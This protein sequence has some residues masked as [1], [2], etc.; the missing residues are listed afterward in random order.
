[1]AQQHEIRL[2]L[3]MNGGVS[4]AVWMGGVAHELDLIRRATTENTPASMGKDVAVANRWRALMQGPGVSDQRRLVIDVIAGTSAGGLNG[5]LLANVIAHNTTLDPAPEPEGEDQEDNDVV[6][7]PWLRSQWCD[8]GTLRSGKLIPDPDAE[9]PP[10]PTGSILDGEFFFKQAERLLTELKGGSKPSSMH[11][12]TLFTTASGL[13]PQEFEARD[14][15]QQPFLV[16]DHRF[17]YRFSNDHLRRYD[18]DALEFH[19]P[20]EEGG[21]FGDIGRLAV[22]ARASASFPVAFAPWNE[23]DLNN[24]ELRQ[25]PRR[26]GTSASWLMDGGVLDNA[27][28][29]PVLATVAAAPVSGHVSRYVMY[30]VPS[31][32]IGKGATT[33]NTAGN[34]PPSW[35]QTAMSVVNFP[36]EVDF[37]SDVE[38]L[39]S[40]RIEADTAWSDTQQAFDAARGSS[41]ERARLLSAAESLQPIYTRGRAAG[42]V[43]EALTVA[44]AG[45]ITALDDSAAAPAKDVDQILQTVPQWTPLE[46]APVNP[47]VESP[48]EVPRWPWGMG[49]AERVVRTVLRAV[50]AQTATAYHADTLA[51]TALDTL[52]SQLTSLTD[53]RRNLHAIRSAAEHEIARLGQPRNELGKAQQPAR[54]SPASEPAAVAEAINEAFENLRVQE[55]LGQEIK[56]VID[57]IPGGAELVRLALAVE[58]VERCM[59][60]R[61]P[62]QRSA[63]FKFIRLGPDIP[64][65]FLSEDDQVRATRLGDRVIYGT[66]VGHFGSFGAEGWRRWDWLMGRLHAVA[67]LGRL[68]HGTSTPEA[69]TAADAWVAETQRAVL[70]AE[71]VDEEEVTATLKDLEDTFPPGP[72]INGVGEMLK[73][74]NEADAEIEPSTVHVGDRLVHS[75]G[76][77]PAGLGRWVKAVAGR[78]EL[79]LD[80][81]H[82]EGASDRLVRWLSEPARTTVWDSLTG[83]RAPLEKSKGWPVI[84]FNPLLW[85]AV[86]A[87]GVVLLIAA[88]M[89]E[90][91]QAWLIGA[92]GAIV[93]TIG[94]LT[95][96]T[97]RAVRRVRTAIA[98]WLTRRIHGPAPQHP[99]GQ[100]TSDEHSISPP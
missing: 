56:R 74:M 69:M 91:D 80:A 5:T 25:L 15:A 72:A 52:E 98:S 37:R 55:A 44:R 10:A 16:T 3:V 38:E 87:L 11:P 40:L 82:R 47:L 46:E 33:I 60:S 89:T 100:K 19:P 58:V 24:Q 22:A 12:I 93:L 57:N 17:L 7:V 29:G 43:W 90:S 67:N 81:D 42:G 27:P 73:A 94:V 45:R 14:A 70:Q 23:G 4:L 6:R 92:I 32:G 64:L 63:P 65:P 85:V 97:V 62:D 39:E 95:T 41:D 34:E 21:D 71:G 78:N 2:A 20:V 76:G 75:S 13:G 36:R 48:G 30:V 18:P 35:K 96:V 77:L 9:P 84:A 31:S 50:R 51:S 8:L 26:A 61:T 28:F 49:P 99:R 66:Q 1:M 59:S 79:A 68:L 53:I 88:A 83:A 86:A 54:I